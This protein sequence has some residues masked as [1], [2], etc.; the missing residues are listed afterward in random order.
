MF[1][2]VKSAYQI[3]RVTYT[4]FRIDTTDWPDDENLTARNMYGI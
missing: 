1:Q 4:R 3:V 2:A